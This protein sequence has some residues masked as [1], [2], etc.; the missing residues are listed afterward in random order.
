MIVRPIESDDEA[1]DALPVLEL[2]KLG[3]TAEQQHVVEKVVREL[4]RQGLEIK[5]VK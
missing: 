3:I 2:S 5:I 4:S 1:Y